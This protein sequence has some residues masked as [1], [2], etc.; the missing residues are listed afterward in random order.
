V[1][2][3][4]QRGDP[5]RGASS[6]PMRPCR[7]HPTDASHVCAVTIGDRPSGAAIASATP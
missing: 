6:T 1:T 2:G 4:G 5:R 7:R 3:S